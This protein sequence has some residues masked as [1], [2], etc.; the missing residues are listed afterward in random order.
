MA[1]ILDSDTVDHGARLQHHLHEVFVVQ[2]REVLEAEQ[3]E[4]VLR[5]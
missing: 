1:Q 2:L 5:D 4:V 3:L